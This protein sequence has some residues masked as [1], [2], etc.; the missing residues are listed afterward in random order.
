MP[1]TRGG[2]HESMRK[3]SLG[4]RGL[5]GE[6]YRAISNVYISDALLAPHVPQQV[7]SGEHSD[8]LTVVLDQHRIRVAQGRDGILDAAAGAPPPRRPA[9]PRGGPP[10]AAPAPPGGGGSPR[11]APPWPARPPP[12][13]KGPPN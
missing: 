7:L 11:G 2:N 8:R 4:I 1:S 5:A 13:E 3:P 6:Q 12:P 9:G 10:C